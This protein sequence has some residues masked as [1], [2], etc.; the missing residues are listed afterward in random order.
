MTGGPEPNGADTAI[1]NKRSPAGDPL[2]PPPRR[3]VRSLVGIPVEGAGSG[4]FALLLCLSERRLRYCL[5]YLIFFLGVG[6]GAGFGFGAA[7]GASPLM[8]FQ[9]L[10]ALALSLGAPPFLFQLL[11]VSPQK[12]S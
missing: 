5:P 6:F 10:L 2:E 4:V 1:G 9:F 11:R 8:R 7:L 3:G 12:P